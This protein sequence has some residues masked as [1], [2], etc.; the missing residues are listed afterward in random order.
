MR[1]HAASPKLQLLLLLLGLGLCSQN[2]RAQ[3]LIE[4]SALRVLGLSPAQLVQFGLNETGEITVALGN[5]GSPT[6]GTVIIGKPVYPPLMDPPNYDF[7]GMFDYLNAP[8]LTDGSASADTF[9]GCGAPADNEANA[10]YAYTVPVQFSPGSPA[11]DQAFSSTGTKWA[12]PPE[13]W[14]NFPTISNTLASTVFVDRGGCNFLD[15]VFNAQFAN[16][17]AVIIVDNKYG[18]LFEMI[19]PEEPD[20][21]IISLQQSLKIPTVLMTKADGEILKKII[22]DPVASASVEIEIDW[23]QALASNSST[24]EWELWTTS[25]SSGSTPSTV[26]DTTFKQAWYD[27]GL[28][29]AFECD[30]PESLECAKF[31]AHYFLGKC[32]HLG[33]QADGTTCCIDE[34]K[35]CL[36]Y[37]ILSTECKSHCFNSGRYCS[38]NFATPFP[39]GFTGQ[40]IV[41]EDL[42][43]LCVWEYAREQNDK[44]IWWLYTTLFRS[45]CPMDAN[46]GAVGK[47]GK[48]CSNNVIAS[49][50]DSI[51]DSTILQAYVNS[52]EAAAALAEDATHEVPLLEN[53]LFAS[54]ADVGCTVGDVDC[55]G[56]I[57]ET[58][59]VLVSN[60]ALKGNLDDFLV[61]GALCA[62]FKEGA[63]PPMCDALGSPDCLAEATPAFGGCWTNGQCIDPLSPDCVSACV[64]TYLGAICICPSNYYS[65]EE[66]G[67]TICKPVP[68]PEPPGDDNSGNAVTVV[69]VLVMLV[70]VIVGGGIAFYIYNRRLRRSMDSE[71][72]GIMAEYMP[73]EGPPDKNGIGSSFANDPTSNLPS[74]SSSLE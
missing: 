73:I 54:M 47:F 56:E 64:E 39:D 19:F 69:I 46:V 36:T 25:D 31:T 50:D 9:L 14:K 48:T 60:V 37:D 63:E 57:G 5:I 32:C 35:T 71:I 17:D 24:V 12:V 18:D 65:T 52:C 34:D 74:I 28:E 59:T 27:S 2:V 11:M 49:L 29:E 4:T 23:A 66:D 20:E 58:P 26:E 41:R 33:F 15:K 51:V 62:A 72:R 53:E 44:T 42:R 67:E 7:D 8:T 13:N 1:T 68:E 70:I 38:P 40:D 6:Y 16:A 43:Q 10:P 45:N 3:Y 61:A 21:W 22:A 55:Q 30:T